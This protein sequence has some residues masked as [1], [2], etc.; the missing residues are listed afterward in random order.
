MDF[1]L[2]KEQG[3][4]S[5][6]LWPF[7]I[8]DN[9][10]AGRIAGKALWGSIQASRLFAPCNP[11]NCDHPF[12][13]IATTVDGGDGR[14]WVICESAWLGSFPQ[15]RGMPGPR[16]PVRKIRDGC[17]PPACPNARSPSALG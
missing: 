2:S 13:A 8:A 4:L 15:E 3:V 16:L 11:W 1:S 12:R 6:P 5:P 14:R 10:A 17:P 7:Y 9:V